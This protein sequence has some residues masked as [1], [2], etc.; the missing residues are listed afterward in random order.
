MG[1][2]Q[3]TSGEDFESGEIVFSGSGVGLAEWSVTNRYS[4]TMS[5]D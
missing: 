2:C 1:E 5:L 3:T 4:S